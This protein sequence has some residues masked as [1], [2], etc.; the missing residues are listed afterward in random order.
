MSPGSMPRGMMQRQHSADELKRSYYVPKMI[1]LV[2]S[3]GYFE[4]VERILLHLFTCS[5]Q[6]LKAPLEKHILNIVYEIPRPTRGKFK[7][8]YTAP[9]GKMIPIFEP[10]CNDLPY[11]NP[12]YVDKLVEAVNFDIEKVLQIV[13]HMLFEGSVAF[14]SNSNDKLVGVI[15]AVQYLMHPFTYVGRVCHYEPNPTEQFYYAPFAM[16]FGVA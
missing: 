14:V 4:Y 9:N 10:A 2:A 3:K 8:K 7:I 16:C 6:F 12:L 5:R 11:Y 13:R 15:E 1:C